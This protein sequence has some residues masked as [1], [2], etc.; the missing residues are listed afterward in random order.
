MTILIIIA[1][2]SPDGIYTD[3]L[4]C[5]WWFIW[6]IEYSHMFN[7]DG[8]ITPANEFGAFD[9]RFLRRVYIMNIT[10]EHFTIPELRC[11]LFESRY[12]EIVSRR[13]VV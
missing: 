13:A 1:R 6:R 3:L 2:G 10:F 8:K 11:E 4:R 12:E 5:N 9:E 7:F